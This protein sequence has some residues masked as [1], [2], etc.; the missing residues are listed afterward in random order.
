MNFNGLAVNLKTN[1][2]TKGI[3]ANFQRF[4]IVRSKKIC[5]PKQCL[6]AG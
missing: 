4:D 2:A 1:I 3:P 5:K 6:E